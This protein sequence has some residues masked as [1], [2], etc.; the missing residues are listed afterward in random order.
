MILFPQDQPQ[1]RSTLPDTN[2]GMPPQVSTFAGD[3]DGLYQFTFWISL[4]FFVLITGILVYSLFKWHRKTE[5]QPAASNE[6]HNTTLEVTWTV[7]PLIIV[8]VIFAW[9]WKGSLDMTVAPPDALTYQVRARKW[10]WSITHPNHT[11]PL[12]NEIYVPLGRPVKFITS[13]E[14]VLHSL[15]FPAMRAKRDVLPGRLQMVWF[16]ATQLGTF[17]FFCTEYCGERHSFMIG[18]VHVVPPE[19]FEAGM[20]A[21]KYQIGVDPNL[22]AHENGKILYTA[23]GCNACHS[24]TSAAVNQPCPS[25]V[26]LWGREEELIDGTKVTVDEPYFLESVL[27]PLA[28]TVKGYARGQMPPQAIT[29]EEAR[30]IMEYVKTLK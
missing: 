16:T 10:S 25:F 3:V 23:K 13:S 21:R 27:D 26:G 30:M 20:R 24:T 5:D 19:E 7:I 18:E 28:K 6:T 4:F 14:D 8:M 11:A 12:T 1:P 22:P 29:E 2:W 15:F 9:G 17:P